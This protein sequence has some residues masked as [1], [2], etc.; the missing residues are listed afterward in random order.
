MDRSTQKHI[1]KKILVL[2]CT[3]DQKNRKDRKNITLDKKHTYNILKDRTLP[4]SENKSYQIKKNKIK[5]N[6]F[7]NNDDMK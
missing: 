5:P 3:L 2:S 6:M 1:Y 4:R 7:S